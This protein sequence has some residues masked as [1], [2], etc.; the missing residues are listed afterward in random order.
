ME[1]AG[2]SGKKIRHYHVYVPDNYV[3]NSRF[4]HN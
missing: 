2:T 3:A 1:Q 4:R